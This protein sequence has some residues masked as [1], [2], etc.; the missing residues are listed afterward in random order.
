MSK[1]NPGIMT[2]ELGKSDS[3]KKFVLP[4]ATKSY[5]IKSRGNFAFQLAYM[6]NGFDNGIFET[7]PANFA[8]NEE[9]LSLTD[10]LIIWA[11]GE[12]ANDILEVKIW[13]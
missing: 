9:D 10:P 1:S 5:T 12:K 7:V 3:V 2:V 13:R 4:G 8:V 6:E 11:K